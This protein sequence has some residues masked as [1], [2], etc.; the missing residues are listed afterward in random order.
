MPRAST[1]SEKVWAQAIHAVSVQKMSLRRAAQ[2]YG[3]HHMSLHRRVRG[4]YL[5]ATAR[6]SSSSNNNSVADKFALS[7]AEQDEVLLVLREQFLHERQVT[8]DDVRYV[9]RTIASQS[10]CRDLPSDFPPNRW[11]AAFKRVHGFMQ[12]DSNNAAAAA[13]ARS[14]V[15]PYGDNGSRSSPHSS[16]TSSAIEQGGNDVVHSSRLPGPIARYS[17]TNN[18]RQSHSA[19]SHSQMYASLSPPQQQQQQ[20]QSSRGYAALPRSH[21]QNS[22]NGAVYY[23]DYD[24]DGQMMHGST[25]ESDSENTRD[26]VMNDDMDDATGNGQRNSR[27]IN[28]V[29]AETWEKAMDAVEIH[30]MSLRNAAKAYGVHFAALHRRIKKRTRQKEAA[31][32]LEN[33]IPFEDEAG[34]VRVIHARADLG[35]LMSYEELVDV[36]VRSKLKYVATVSAELSRSLIRRFQSRV[37]HSIR[38][39]ICD[40]PLPRLD[41]LCRFGPPSPQLQLQ[42][43]QHDQYAMEEKV[44]P[45]PPLTPRALLSPALY[46]QNSHHGTS[47]FYERTSPRVM[48]P[49][50]L[51]DDRLSISD[52]LLRPPPPMFQRENETHAAAL[53]SISS[54]HGVMN[55]DRG[56]PSSPTVVLRL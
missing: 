54:P 5:G 39:L 35:V 14:N 32:P 27:Q 45:P 4:Q 28:A 26:S 55:G 56:L 51:L 38:H 16:I 50:A 10:S 36:L 23:D 20:Q 41:S 47:P 52:P 8:A 9:V 12:P 6:S 2:L 18:S 46:Q 24:D 29:S 3:V 37:E 49:P 21:S 53:P 1:V 7:K 33:Y 11:I 15:R 31:P 34:I 48:E 25:S 17:T 13:A 43:R 19:D 44:S 42:L 40:W 30:G 22:S